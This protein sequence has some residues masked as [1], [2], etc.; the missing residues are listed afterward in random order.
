MFSN[1]PMLAILRGVRK[2]KAF[3]KDSEIACH[4]VE[5]Q[6]GKEISL[7]ENEMRMAMHPA[8]QF[9]AF[10]SLAHEGKGAKDIAARFGVTPTLVR[11]RLK[12]AC[13]SPKF[14]QIYRDGQMSFDQLMAFRETKVY[15][16]R[17]IVQGN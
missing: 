15:Q 4:V 14:M 11:Q 7:A 1:S 5:G 2:Q 12:L 13:V 10:K 6:E 9:E 16:Y 8:D 3:D 17:A